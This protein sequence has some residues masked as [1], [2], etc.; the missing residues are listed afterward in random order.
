MPRVA[1]T[2]PNPRR[3]ADALGCA[4]EVVARLEHARDARA[5]GRDPLPGLNAASLFADQV[6]RRIVATVFPESAR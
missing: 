6:S 3:I 5:A 4:R 1:A 2:Q